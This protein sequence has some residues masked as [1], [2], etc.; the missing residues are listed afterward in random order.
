MSSFQIRLFEPGDEAQVVRLLRQVLDRPGTG[1]HDEAFFRWKHLENPF[2]PSIMLVAEAERRIVGF[3]AIMRWRL[4]A[5]GRII[6]AGRPVDTVTDPALRRQGVFS[7]LTKAVLK[8][9]DAHGVELLFNTPNEQSLP[10]YLKMGWTALGRATRD[11]LVGGPLVWTHLLRARLDGPRLGDGPVTDNPSTWADLAGALRP[12]PSSTVHVAKGAAYLRWRY[13]RHPW[14]RYHVVGDG[15]TATVM[16]V[17]AARRIPVAIVAESAARRR[18]HWTHVLAAVATRAGTPVVQFLYTSASGGPTGR[19]WF[20][21]ARLG[22]MIV[23]RSSRS[24]LLDLKAWSL[25]TGELEF[26]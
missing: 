25:G 15:A 14:F 9:L 17:A 21:V 4:E 10:G 3:R 23:V 22:P 26:F 2:G 12:A 20:R 7:A 8:D 24:D 1:A 6:E 13:G 11:I 5:D 18:D 19:G 16:R